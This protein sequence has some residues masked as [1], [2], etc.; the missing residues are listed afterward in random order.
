MEVAA[1]ANL[2]TVGRFPPEPLNIP[3][4]VKRLDGLGCASVA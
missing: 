1:G 2:G 3:R 4:G